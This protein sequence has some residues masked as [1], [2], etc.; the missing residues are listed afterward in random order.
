[1]YA[2]DE[3]VDTFIQGK[4][5]QGDLFPRDTCPR[6][7]GPRRLLSTEAFGGEKLPQLDFCQA[8]LKLQL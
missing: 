3:D 4:V 8:Q 5:V 2:K 1:M 7:I 6:D